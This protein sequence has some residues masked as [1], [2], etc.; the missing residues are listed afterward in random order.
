MGCSHTCGAFL[1]F[2]LEIEAV[3]LIDLD[4]DHSEDS[5]PSQDGFRSRGDRDLAAVVKTNGIPF[6]GFRCT[7]RFRT[8]FSGDWGVCWGCGILTQG[9][10]GSGVAK[11]DTGWWFPFN[12][13]PGD[14]DPGMKPE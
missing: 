11:S 14:F 7:T 2:P 8:Y 10:F 13:A 6:F 5:E 3:S 9:H 1:P 12:L 4:E